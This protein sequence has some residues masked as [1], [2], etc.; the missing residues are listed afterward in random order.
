[1]AALALLM[2]GFVPV[3]DKFTFLHH[4]SRCMA[5]NV[6]ADTVAYTEDAAIIA[7]LTGG[8]T[9]GRGWATHTANGTLAAYYLAPPS[10]TYL[11][12]SGT[13]AIQGTGLAFLH[14]RRAASRPERLVVVKTDMMRNFRALRNDISDHLLD[15]S[16]VRPAAIRSG[17]NVTRQLWEPQGGSPAFGALTIFAGSPDPGDESHFTIDYQTPAGRGTIDGWLQ[18]DDTVKLAVRDGPLAW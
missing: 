2:W 9:S 13:C 11:E 14:S 8:A 18:V 4:Q 7:C 16:V 3:R 15:V 12:Q 1:M 6:P 17:A 5:F 10:L